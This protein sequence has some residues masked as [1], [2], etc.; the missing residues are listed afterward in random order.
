MTVKIEVLGVGC[1]NCKKLFHN[2]E[3][4]VREL[5]LSAEIVKVEDIADIVGKGA[6]ALPA[7]VVDDELRVAGRV[8]PVEEIKRILKD[9]VH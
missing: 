5:G 9:Y 6:L 4:A 2:V 3:T 8:A 1:A 7:L